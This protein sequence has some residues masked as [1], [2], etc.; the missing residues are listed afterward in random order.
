[1]SKWSVPWP[2][3]L[4]GR[5]ADAR[6]CVR[7]LGVRFQVG[8]R[9]H[10]LGDARLVVGAEER[11]AVGGDDVV[12]VALGEERR[13]GGGEAGGEFFA[14]I[15][16]VDLRRD[17]GG[18]R[19]GADVDVRDHAD[20]RARAR[21]RGEDVAVLGQLDVLEAELAQLTLQESR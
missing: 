9:G 1:M 4:V 17:A 3:L 10:D 7:D 11:R 5:E 20:R 13:V 15:V 12:A 6:G 2:D 16:R 21:Q 8:D 19:V 14:L 18:G